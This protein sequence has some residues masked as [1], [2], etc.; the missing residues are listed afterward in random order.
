MGG[1]IRKAVCYGRMGTQ[2][3]VWYRYGDIQQYYPNWKV[4]KPSQFYNG[5][6][7]REDIPHY[8]NKTKKAKNVLNNQKKP[9]KAPTS[10]INIPNKNNKYYNFKDLM[11]KVDILLGDN[12]MAMYVKN[13]KHYFGY[14]DISVK[15]PKHYFGYHDISNSS[16]NNQNLRLSKNLNSKKKPQNTS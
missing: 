8:L 11:M 14:H 10:F 4:F 16:N 3:K 6:R 2:L 15:N 9:P 1:V 5:K 13:P 12:R 7:W